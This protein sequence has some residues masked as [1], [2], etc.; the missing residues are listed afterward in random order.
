MWADPAL[1]LFLSCAA[2]AVMGTTLVRVGASDTEWDAEFLVPAGQG[3]LPVTLPT[4]SEDQCT[5]KVLSHG[6]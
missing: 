4:L 3:Y 2:D 6:R 1:C 5:A